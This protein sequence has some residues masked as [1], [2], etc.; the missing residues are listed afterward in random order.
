MDKALGVLELIGGAPDGLSNADLLE[1]AGLPKTT[2]YRILATLVERGLVRRDPVKR[3]YRLGFR[4]LELVR[5]AYLQ[6][7]LVAAA[8]SEL[9]A[10]R[11]LTGETAYLAVLDGA[12]VLSL[13][14]CDGAHS[15]RSAAA[16]G[17]SKPLHCTGQGKAI[18]SRLPIHERDALLRTI[19][20]PAL[21]RYTI[22]DRRRLQ[23]ELGITAA[24][25]YA[26][27]DEEIVEGVRCVAAPIIDP[28]GKVRGALSVAGPAFRLSLARLELL[29]PEL[30][31]AGRRVGSQLAGNRTRIDSN[32]IEPVCETWAFHGAFP[33][34]SAA[35]DRLYWADTMAPAIRCFD[36]RDDRIVA[37]LDSP[38][39]GMLL[40]GDR[41]FVDL[42][43]ERIWVGLQ[44]DIEPIAGA[45][46]WS[47][48]SI[49]IL[50]VDD[51]QRAWACQR[52][53]AEAGCRVGPIREDGRFMTQWR[54]GEAIEAMAMTRDGMD[55]YAIAPESGTLYLLKS[56]E[57][58]GKAIVRRVAS[59][60]KGSGRL[61][62]LA[63]DAEGGIWTSL[64]DGWSLVRFTEDGNV[65]TLK[66]L[67]VAA[68]T[69]IAIASLL[70]GPFLYITSDRHLQSL[71]LLNSAP[72]SGML[73]R[74]RLRAHDST[75]EK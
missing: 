66:S 10:L 25:G 41:L 69:G 58:G 46:A 64:K 74:V 4:Y 27:D 16:L 19:D 63:L 36:G 68:P 21:T 22:T 67:P 61:S 34:W 28:A 55:A 70:D 14:R 8:S 52:S 23:I 50:C 59:M 30:A 2:L 62:G 71:E 65:D 56:A 47:D 7:D 57:S 37:R 39:V 12:S 49:G 72:W 17:Q 48:P 3:V 54:V 1:V 53:D 73:L 29:G 40:F 13:E 38:I 26:I 60:P 24:R 51:A 31:D 75:A 44:G 5:N 9:R 18:L 35:H 45:S 15:R 11:D 42:G 33:C 6:P 43:S 20:Y 32:D